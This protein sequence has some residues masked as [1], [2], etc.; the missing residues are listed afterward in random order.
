MLMC[1]D[2]RSN[3]V[4]GSNRFQR[5]VDY[6]DSTPM[7]SSTF[8]LSNEMEVR[9]DTDTVTLRRYNQIVSDRS[10]HESDAIKKNVSGLPNVARSLSKLMI[11][12]LF[13]DLNKRRN[14]RPF[15]TQNYTTT[16]SEIS[17]HGLI[18]WK[19]RARA[20]R[21][22]KRAGDQLVKNEEKE[23]TRRRGSEEEGERR[24]R[25]EEN[26]G[27]RLLQSE[28][29][30]EE[31]RSE[32]KSKMRRRNERKGE[33][34]RQN[35]RGHKHNRRRSSTYIFSLSKLIVIFSVREIE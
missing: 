18:V 12:N 20:L 25:D 4:E 27:T 8:K 32:G 35:R 13:S 2:N 23:E 10:V 15:E 33:K 21:R 11:Y 7:V 29:K 3:H 6:N 24:R 5:S 14:F 31:R 34:R 26:G 28:D 9:D 19:P 17:D 22:M 1:Q 16:E 30:G